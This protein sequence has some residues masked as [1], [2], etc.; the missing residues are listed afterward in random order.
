MNSF[1]VS[2]YSLFII[3][4]FWSSI[5]TF[6]LLFVVRNIVDL[7]VVYKR[8]LHSICISF[9]NFL[10]PIGCVVFVRVRGLRINQN[11]K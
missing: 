2:G 11:R 1:T 5:R 8:N 9:A 6:Y 4:T 10:R 7:A 3:D